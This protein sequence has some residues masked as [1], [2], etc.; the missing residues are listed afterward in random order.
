MDQI[1]IPA[2]YAALVTLL[3]NPLTMGMLVTWLLSHIPLI[4]ND[5]VTN[6]V[7]FTVAVVVCLVWSL[8]VWIA[9]NGGLPTSTAMWYSALYVGLAV[10]VANQ[11][12]YQV[13]QHIPA[14][15]DFLLAFAGKPSVP[16]TLTSTTSS[17]DGGKTSTTVATTTVAQTV[18]E[19]LVG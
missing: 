1:V 13:L 4:K 17:G 16:V 8:V 6:W 19:G 12:F 18:A 11:A 5:N 10:V 7:K 15:R 14:L 3:V 2:D 9:K